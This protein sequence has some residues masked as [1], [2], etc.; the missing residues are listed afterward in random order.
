MSVASERSTSRGRGLQSTGRGG[1]GNIR[2]P[3]RDPIEP[4]PGPEDYSDPRGRDPIPS[5]DPGLVTSTGRGGAGNIRSPSRDAI[6]AENGTPDASPSRSEVRGRGYDRD[7]IE[8][9]DNANDNGVHSYGRGGAGNMT[10]SPAHSKSRSRSREPAHTGGRGGYGNAHVGGPSEKIIEEQDESERASHQHPPGVHSVGRGGTGNLTAGEVPHREGAGNPYGANH[11][12]STHSHIAESHGRGGIG[13][14]SR[15]P[16]REPG[17]KN[18]QN[19]LSG[20][21]HSVTGA[22]RKN[23]PRGRSTGRDELVT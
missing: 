9:I 7:L 8:A 4:T 14:I 3:S 1:A 13:N 12:H 15:E 20:I 22:V 18:P 10:G 11:P 17:V 23:E 6:R 2:S 21:L 19:V 16:S 5:R